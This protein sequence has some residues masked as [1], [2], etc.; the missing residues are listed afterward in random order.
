MEIDGGPLSLSDIG[1]YWVRGRYLGHRVYIDLTHINLY[2][3]A[4]SHHHLLNMLAMFSTVT[5][6]QNHLRTGILPCW[7]GIPTQNFQAE[8][9]DQQADSLDSQITWIGY[10]K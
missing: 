2:L 6:N 8:Q 7:T 1:I 10:T 3:I 9:L 5:Q 4:W